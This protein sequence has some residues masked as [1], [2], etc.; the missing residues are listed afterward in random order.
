[1]AIF[2]LDMINMPYE[3]AKRNIVRVNNICAWKKW[4]SLRPD[5]VSFGTALHYTVIQGD[6]EVVDEMI[7][8]IRNLDDAH[9]LVKTLTNLVHASL[10]LEKQG[11]QEEIHRTVTNILYLINS[12]PNINMSSQTQLAKALVYATL[13][14]KDGVIAFNLRNSL[15]RKG[16]QWDDMEQQ[17]LRHAIAFL[18]KQPSFTL[19]ED[20]DDML[21]QLGIKRMS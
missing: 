8:R 17:R 20:K 21:V 2:A 6:R 10:A 19:P 13:H 7:E 12:F 14:A 18:L 3:A 1:M 16:A 9:I 11:S 5:G 4:M 15:L